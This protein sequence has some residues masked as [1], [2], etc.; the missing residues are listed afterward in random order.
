MGALRILIIVLSL[1]G[2]GFMLYIFSN[3]P[4]SRLL[5]GSYAAGLALNAWYVFS[6]GRQTNKPSRV[7]GLVR[8]WFEAKEAELKKRAAKADAT[9]P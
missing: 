3:E 7:F 2:M 8:L 5:T 1:A 4:Q 6:I 9:Q